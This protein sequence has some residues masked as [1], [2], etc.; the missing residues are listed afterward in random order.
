MGCCKILLKYILIFDTCTSSGLQVK[1]TAPNLGNK[2][3]LSYK[4]SKYHGE[5]ECAF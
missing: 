2:V 5:T 3:I 4:D 1:R